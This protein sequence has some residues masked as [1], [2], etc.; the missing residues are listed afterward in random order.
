MMWYNNPGA[1]KAIDEAKREHTRNRAMRTLRL[2]A[3]GN[4]GK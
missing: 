4:D 2:I 3:G 1:V